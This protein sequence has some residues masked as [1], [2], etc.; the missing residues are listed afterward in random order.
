M[1]I[2]IEIKN[3]IDLKT[4]IPIKSEADLSSK[5]LGTSILETSQPTSS[6]YKNLSLD[7]KLIDINFY[8][9]NIK[10]STKSLL[11]SFNAVL[12]NDLKYIDEYIK[13]KYI[14]KNIT[15]QTALMLACYI[16]NYE[17]VIK[18][19]NK[20]IGYVDLYDRSALFYA[21]NAISPDERIIKLISEY[22]YFI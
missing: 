1:S 13:T 19:L 8:L 14:Y 5:D 15:L 21:K 2:N 7:L 16:G 4:S 11:P 22:E 17:M 12:N 6:L 18:L 20:E 3:K 10:D 9:D